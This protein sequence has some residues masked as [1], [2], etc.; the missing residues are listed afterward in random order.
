MAQAMTDRIPKCGH[1]DEYFQTVREFAAHHQQCH[2]TPLCIKLCESCIG[3]CLRIRETKGELDVCVRCRRHL[4]TVEKK[5]Q[6]RPKKVKV[7]QT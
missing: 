2:T 4:R 1:C 5:Q 6:P 3:R 7:E